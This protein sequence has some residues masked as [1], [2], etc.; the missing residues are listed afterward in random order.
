MARHKGRGGR[1]KRHDAVSELQRARHDYNLQQDDAC[2]VIRDSCPGHSGNP[3][4][5]EASKL[6]EYEN[7]R[8]TPSLIHVQAMCEAYQRSAEELGLIKWRR[9]INPAATEATRNFPHKDKP[10]NEP[11]SPYG[12]Y[13]DSGLESLVLTLR[14]NDLSRSI[15][16]AGEAEG[17]AAVHRN[18]FLKGMGAVAGAAATDPFIALTQID[19]AALNTTTVNV[20]ALEQLEQAAYVHARSYYEL[21]LPGR[22]EA[23]V[24]DWAAAGRLLHQSQTPSQRI[25]L[26]ESYARLSGI[27][28]F[29]N[30]DNGN[31]ARAE[32]L[33]TSGEDAAREAGNNDLLVWLHDRHAEVY[34]F[35]GNPRVR[36]SVIERGLEEA[37]R[38]ETLTVARLHGAAATAYASTGDRRWSLAHRDEAARILTKGSSGCWPSDRSMPRG[39]S[40][41]S[42]ALVSFTASTHYGLGEYAKAVQLYRETIA[43]K[44]KLSLSS[45][46]VSSMPLNRLHLAR[47]LVHT[48][49]LEEATQTATA[50]VQKY[51]GV[52]NPLVLNRALDF[53]AELTAADTSGTYARGFSE[54][55]REQA[56]PSSDN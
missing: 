16:A 26:S 40:F 48:G 42:D 5:L 10:A 37:G 4:K 23:L 19:R 49:E 27:L 43:Q 15:P 17:N 47:A 6:S 11:F 38:T 53:G 31:R 36:M 33:F 7:G 56:R 51:D 29:Y 14:G 55:L 8:R 28:G 9:R 22:A 44:E 54:F 25:R 35:G 20:T 1:G 2:L 18:T 45:E 3:C 24:T 12:V 34:N 50:A 39:Y 32:A 21:H 30:F 13:P 52:A 46:T 41:T